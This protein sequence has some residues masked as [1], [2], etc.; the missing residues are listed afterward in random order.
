MREHLNEDTNGKISFEEDV[1]CF[2]WQC[3]RKEGVVQTVYGM[4]NEMCAWHYQY[5]L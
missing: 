3:K 5:S 1:H 4:I 2:L